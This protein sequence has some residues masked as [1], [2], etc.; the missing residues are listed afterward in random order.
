MMLNLTGL[1]PERSLIMEKM[2]DFVFE[3]KTEREAR[4]FAFHAA[5]EEGLWCRI[6]HNKVVVD[7]IFESTAEE[8]NDWIKAE[9]L[10]LV[11]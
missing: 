4:I 6:R 10:E 8:L 3:F 5:D 11:L 7:S 2:Y 9:G 1:C